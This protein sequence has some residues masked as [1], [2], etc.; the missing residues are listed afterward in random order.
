MRRWSST[1]TGD[2]PRSTRHSHRPVC[3]RK[4]FLSRSGEAATLKA[5]EWALKTLPVD[6]DRVSVTGVSMGGTGT[7]Y[8]AV[9]YPELFSAASP[10]C[11][12]HSY[13]IRRDTSKRP[14]RP[15]ENARMHHWSPASWAENLRQVPMF[16]AQGT[17]DFPHDNSKVLIQRL[18][19]LSYD[20]I[21]EWPE[22]GHSVWTEIWDGADGWP[23]L[24]SKRRVDTPPEVRFV[25]DQLRYAKHYWV[26]V[27]GLETPGKLAEVK[28][29]V[30]AGKVA[31]DV[32]GITALRF[33]PPLPKGLQSAKLRA[34][35]AEQDLELDVEKQ[36]LRRSA[37]GWS[38][39]PIAAVPTG[40][41]R[42]GVEGPI[43]DVFLEPVTFV[44]GTRR[45]A[46][47]RATLEVAKA[48]ANGRGSADISY[49]VVADRDLPASA[50]TSSNLFLIGGARDNLVSARFAS[51]LKSRTETD[52][53]MLGNAEFAGSDVGCLY[54]EPHPLSPEHYLLVLDAVSAQGY[55]LT[56]TL[57]A[58]LPDFIVY[59]TSVVPAAGQQVLGD[60][61]VRAGGFFDWDWS[62]PES[63]Q[64]PEAKP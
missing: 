21:E 34:R 53:L 30:K 33:V 62:L 48:W 46:T 40:H 8:M 25:T 17:K 58:L 61:R 54:I 23:W 2:R 63:V 32:S 7:G 38:V 13:F 4:P 12:Y 1:P 28:A 50:M 57:P 51:G 16:V 18:R 52:K 19:D 49:P 41:K 10:L 45:Q 22:T 31:V 37:E 14:I 6:A 36:E 59:D 29:S 15:W 56:N 42:R 60:A 3:P 64:D 55:L 5:L 24:S 35:V 20:V 44:Y 43:R 26:E 27:T 39:S 9:R 11:G 47:S